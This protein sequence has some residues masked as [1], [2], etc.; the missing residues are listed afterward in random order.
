MFTSDRAR[1]HALWIVPAA[2]GTPTRVPM[3]A[4]N[5]SDAS[6]SRDG[7][8]MVYAQVFEDT[9]IWRFDLAGKAAPKKIV[10]STQYDSSPS[11]APDGNRIAFRSNRSG[12]NEIWESDSEGRAAW[13]VTHVGG[14]L[15]GTP[16]WSPDGTRLVFDSRPLGQAEIYTM[17]VGSAMVRVTNSPSEDVT[18][19]WSHDGKWIYFA[20]NR[21][22]AW[23]VW[24][25]PST[26][27]GPDEQVTRLGGFAGF[28]S[29]DG[30]HLYYAKGRGAE[31]LWRKRLPDGPEEVFVPELRA[32]LWGYWALSAKGLYYFDWAGPGKLATIWW[33]PFSGRRTQ[34][35]TVEGPLVPPIPAW[36]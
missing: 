20:S 14:A 25:T 4:E 5:A 21:S 29:E 16:R 36:R 1:N 7:R 10:A 3:V 9:N 34:V 19:S 8:N 17:R 31:G 2:G 12:S 23:Q 35:G 32:G 6:F 22:G 18:P 11:I 26:G 13:Q 33:Q 24:R 27:G 15:T 28:E 30:Q